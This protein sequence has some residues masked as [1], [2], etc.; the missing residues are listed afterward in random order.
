MSTSHI[1]RSG[2]VVLLSIAAWVLIAASAAHAGVQDIGV[3]TSNR[4]ELAGG[5]AGAMLGWTES[6]TAGG[7]T[8]NGFV[9]EIGGGGDPI[10]VNQ[11]GREAFIGGLS[12]TT[13]VFQQVD[14]GGNH[15]IYRFDIPTEERTKFSSQVNTANGFEFHPTLS[16]GRLLFGRRNLDTDVETIRVFTLATG[17]TRVLDTIT[18]SA[19]RHTA[20]GQI[21]GR[22]AVWHRC[23]PLCNVFVWNRVADSI[24]RL[25]RPAGTNQQWPAVTGD[26]VV[27]YLREGVACDSVARIVKDP[28]DGPA[29]VIRTLPTGTTAAHLSASPQ[30]GDVTEVLYSRIDCGPPQ[31]YDLFKIVDSP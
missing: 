10:M 3:K 15:N 23:A 20:P 1:H 9:E 28:P 30:G 16:Q 11:A 22:F 2:S 13:V 8:F 4:N 24:T 31:T 14:P 19:T 18:S 21:R 29:Q 12:G 5:L 17:T 27:Y 26:G 7:S 6:T 25:P